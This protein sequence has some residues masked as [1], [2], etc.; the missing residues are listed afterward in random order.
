MLT[1]S[2]YKE[3]SSTK[4]GVFLSL[5]CTESHLSSVGFPQACE[6]PMLSFSKTSFN[7]VYPQATTQFIFLAV[8]ARHLTVTRICS[9][10]FFSSQ[11]P[12]LNMNK[13]SFYHSNQVGFAKI[14]SNLQTDSLN[15]WVS[16][17]PFPVLS[18]NFP[19]LLFSC[20]LISYNCFSSFLPH[21]FVTDFILPP[22]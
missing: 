2:S 12:H 14:N 9:V 18:G 16:I 7:C 17:L 3:P 20:F 13:L 1:F 19:C 6:P 5:M 10:C 4:Y 21:V 15:A 22:S 8:T 11:S